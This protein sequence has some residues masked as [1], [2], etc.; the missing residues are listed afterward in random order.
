M[1]N[2]ERGFCL[3]VE[4]HDADIMASF[5]DIEGQLMGDAATIQVSEEASEYHFMMG[6]GHISQQPNLSPWESGC[7]SDNDKGKPFVTGKTTGKWQFHNTMYT[8]EIIQTEVGFIPMDLLHD[9]HY[10]NYC[11]MSMQSSL[12]WKIYEN[13]SAESFYPKE[14]W[15]P[16]VICNKYDTSLSVWILSLVRH[17][18]G[19]GNFGMCEGNS[20]ML[21]RMLDGSNRGFQTSVQWWQL[22]IPVGIF[23]KN[24]PCHHMTLKMISKP[25]STALQSSHEFHKDSELHKLW[26]N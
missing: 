20:V 10:R 23:C 26:I 2:Y 21:S 11:I 9:N 25:S 12:Y 24:G 7:V 15:F 17:M 4:G 6:G 19:I 13:D 1:W 22:L 16:M 18:H 3:R 8:Y 14:G 5:I